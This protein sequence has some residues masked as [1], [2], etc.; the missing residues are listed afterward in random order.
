MKTFI[1]RPKVKLNL[2]I[3]VI[4]CVI[5]G[6]FF[7]GYTGFNLLS[8][9]RAYVAGE[10]LWAKAQKE[11][12]YQLIQY[13]F[14]GD[15]VRYQA[16]LDALQVIQSDRAARLELDS[17]N[18][19]NKIVYEEFIKGGNH[20][21]DIPI[22]IKLYK[23]FK[24]I[25]Y[26]RK[27]I[28]QWKIAD[29]LIMDLKK[30]GE[31]IHNHIVTNSMDN[32]Q[33]VQFLSKIDVL[34]Q[35]LNEAE[36]LFSYNI[37]LASQW[38]A[39]TL[40]IIIL[41]FSA[42]GGIICFIMIRL[43]AGII[44][45]LNDKNIKLIDQAET[46]RA[47]REELKQSEERFR[48]LAENAPDVIYRMTLPE[49][50]YEYV[51]PASKDV[52]GYLPEEFYE[53]PLLIQK[54][55][56]PDWHDY[57][58]TQWDNLL[59]GKM[60]PFYEYP[61]ITKSGEERWINQRNVFIR[62]NEET[63]VAIEGIVT[64]I[65]EQKNWEQEKEHLASELRQ[66]HKMEAIGTLAGGIAHDFNNILSAVIGFSELVRRE[67]S[68]ILPAREY[69]DEVLKASSRAQ[70]IVRQIMSFN[71]RSTGLQFP[72][73]VHNIAEEAL[74][75]LRASIPATIEI[76]EKIDPN[77]GSIMADPTQIHQVIMNLCSNAIQAME[78]KGGVL[79]ITLDSIEIHENGSETAPELKVG[80]YVRMIIS[81][82][83]SGIAP[84][85]IER[86]Y[87]PYF[88][89][90]ETGKGIGMGLAVVHGIINSIDGTISV[91][92]QKGQGTKFILYFRLVEPEETQKTTKM[93]VFP[94]ELKGIENILFVDDEDSIVNLN[95][96]RLKQLGY[97]VTSKTLSADALDL[98]CSESDKFDLV[99]T[100]QTMPMMTGEQLAKEMLKIRP[101]IPIILCTG[102]SF[103]IND[104]K[105]REI[106]IKA[107]MVKPVKHDELAKTI[108]QV[109]NETV[110]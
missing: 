74:K 68:E 54:I 29:R 89:T 46:E 91:D 75:L 110:E 79:Q 84:N 24:N 71:R 85:D 70:E 63:P 77:C 101:D 66:A 12:T 65:T 20:P 67:I 106:G 7:L 58:A 27:A 55:M 37:T 31:D 56:H 102:N 1:L 81:D 43:I 18:P 39:H 47:I 19:D 42:A 98:F 33:R 76:Q 93:E 86:I 108:R 22:L 11:S 40:C 38:A 105:V 4:L 34:Q 16:F 2:A 73:Q 82:T 45:E 61:I 72:I 57:F 41:I 96:K 50:H 52:F 92:S 94:D 35:Q 100:D 64:D 36:V 99:I 14:T 23:R 109:L 103:A 32:H 104:E 90:K 59:A 30:V 3:I 49:G 25:G 51:S 88:T 107:F 26:M 87:D 60:P 53:Q 48:R 21:Q 28:E 78:E 8:G 13:A 9:L 15:T 80:S 95:E 62:D 44:R 83:G 10:G 6:L 5:S 97:K 69:I 17:D